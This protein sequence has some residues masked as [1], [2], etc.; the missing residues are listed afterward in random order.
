MSIKGYIKDAINYAT[1]DIKKLIVGGFLG[2][3]FSWPLDMIG[4]LLPDNPE[5]LQVI[6]E[7]ML[8]LL[9]GL[10]ICFM[11]GIVAL[12]IQ[13]GYFV[14][15]MRETINDSKTLPE[16]EGFLKL[17]IDGILYSIGSL[18][19]L[20]IFMIP[21]IAL[22]I[23]CALTGFALLTTSA[24]LLEIFGAFSIILIILVFISGF[25]LFL[26]YSPLAVV[27]FAN[28]GFFGFF[29][30]RKIFKMAMSI[31]YIILLVVMYVALLVCV[32][33]P[34]LVFG[35]IEWIFTSNGDYVK[36]VLI[37]TADSLVVEFTTFFL[38]VIFHRVFSNYYKNKVR[39][40]K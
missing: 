22:L 9:M 30:F 33:I 31:E 21:T 17:F 4:N 11:V 6:P 8:Y 32:G 12:M 5:A 16:W 26:V 36:V 27:N 37:T 38:L 40:W 19:L 15:I 39:N 14:R 18:V 7:K 2:V 25:L 28:R 1:S 35:V 34:S 3:L 24:N 29:E 10:G 20:L 23:L 13:D